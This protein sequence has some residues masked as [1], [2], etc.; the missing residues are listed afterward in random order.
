MHRGFNTLDTVP[1]SLFEL[2]IDPA[3]VHVVHPSSIA[4]P[5][6][7]HPGAVSPNQQKFGDALLDQHPIVVVPSVVSRH[8][9]N[10][11]INLTTAQGSFELKTRE[12]F[13]LDARL[14]ASV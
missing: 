11:L 7:L 1:H 14:V 9:W 3:N 10:L 8:S 2:N 4:N 6:W 5:L 13:G 12:A